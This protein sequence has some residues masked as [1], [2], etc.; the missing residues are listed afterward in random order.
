[1]RDN[2]TGDEGEIMK[3]YLDKVE[4]ASKIENLAKAN[5]KQRRFIATVTRK[6]VEKKLVEQGASDD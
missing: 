4:A 2:R 1:M 3:N 6:I 5:R